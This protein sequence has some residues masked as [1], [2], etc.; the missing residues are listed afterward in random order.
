MK[1]F[2]IFCMLSLSLL[3]QDTVGICFLATT[4]TTTKKTEEKTVTTK[5]HNSIKSWINEIEI[6]NISPNEVG[7]ILKEKGFWTKRFQVSLSS[8][9]KSILQEK[10]V[11]FLILVDCKKSKDQIAVR[12]RIL[13]IHEAESPETFVLKAMDIDNTINQFEVQYK[14]SQLYSYLQ[15]YIEEKQS[16]L[17][18]EPS[19]SEIAKE[20]LTE[21]QGWFGETMPQGLSRSNIPGEYL[22]NRDGSIMVYVPAGEFFQGKDEITKEED[23]QDELPVKTI[24]LP[25]YYIDKYEVT[26]EQYCRFLNSLQDK[27]NIEKYIDLN[28]SYCQI[29]YDSTTQIYSSLLCAVHAPVIEISWYG[30][31]EYAK[32]INKSLPSEA[33]WEKAARGGKMIPIEQ[34]TSIPLTLVENP[35]PMRAYPWGN[36]SC[37]IPFIRANVMQEQGSLQNVE[38]YEGLGDSPYGCVNMAGNVWEWCQDLYPN[39]TTRICKGGSWG[40]NEES[41]RCSYRYAVLPS[42]KNNDLGFRCVIS[43][44]E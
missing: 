25:A 38:E 36:N 32:W 1:F 40:S 15:E 27:S 18:R 23:A 11:D 28:S 41:V 34:F 19:L 44:Q 29:K 8:D 42:N 22:W 4:T 10:K 31:V 24:S 16:A 12:G 35:I 17:K 39:S 33:E 26:N 43:T 5:I 3:A 9:I 6:N 14:K 13:S 30:A 2:L 37:D 20:R 21:R 7:P